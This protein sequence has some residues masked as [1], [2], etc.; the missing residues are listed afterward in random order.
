[1]GS[2]RVNVNGSRNRD[3]EYEYKDGDD[4]YEDGDEDAD[5]YEDGDDGDDDNP[6]GFGDDNNPTG[7]GD[8]NN[9]T[10]FGGS[11]ED[12]F[13]TPFDD[14]QEG[15]GNEDVNRNN[16]NDK[17]DKKDKKKKNQDDDANQKGKANVK[18]KKNSSKAQMRKDAL[19]H[20]CASSPEG[21]C[22]S[23]HQMS[24]FKSRRIGDFT[25]MQLPITIITRG[26][27]KVTT[28]YC[29]N[30]KCKK[31]YWSGY[32]YR[33]AGDR[34]LGKKALMKRILNIN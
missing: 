7:F 2:Y 28:F 9:P 6:T 23:C 10:G 31:N 27:Q 3:Y 29:F 22:P 14:D 15:D 11:P 21:I 24:I 17:K 4:E 8:D 19:K 33:C 13:D 25:F 32:C 18:V 26:G 34:F 20:A 16:K 30:R 5:E 12:D 1:M